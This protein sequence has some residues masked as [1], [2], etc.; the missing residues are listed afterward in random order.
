VNPPPGDQM[1]QS[2][3]RKSRVGPRL[4]LRAVEVEQEPRQLLNRF[5]AH[6]REVGRVVDDLGPRGQIDRRRTQTTVAY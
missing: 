2:C 1:V 3:S 6:R 5:L 4:E